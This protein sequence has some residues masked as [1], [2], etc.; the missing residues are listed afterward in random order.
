MIID[1]SLDKIK[2]SN[3]II[4]GDLLHDIFSTLSLK[5][6]DHK[7]ISQ[8]ANAKVKLICDQKKNKI[9]LVEKDSLIINNLIKNYLNH[10][11]WILL[12]KNYQINNSDFYLA[13][14]LFKL[15]TL[16]PINLSL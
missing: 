3:L 2:P 16:L 6:Q 11:T 10:N 9:A 13:Q 8:Y 15:T 5:D 1:V 4:V 12:N 7:N 14:K